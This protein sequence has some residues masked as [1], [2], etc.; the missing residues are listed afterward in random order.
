MWRSVSS[1]PTTTSK[2]S[3]MPAPAKT[4]STVGLRFAVTT[5]SRRP[6][7]SQPLEHGDDAVEA[8]ELRVLRVVVLAVH[9]DELVDALGVEQLHLV[10]EVRAADL[11]E[12]LLVRK[13]PAQDRFRR[14]VE[15]AEDRRGGVDERAVEIEEDDRKPHPRRS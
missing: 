7:P 13:T 11:R 4:R 2:K 8:R 1:E 9:A 6:S 14:V 3:P 12:D 10:R 15:G 5:P